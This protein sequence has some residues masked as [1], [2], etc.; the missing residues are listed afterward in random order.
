MKLKLWLLFNIKIGVLFV[1]MDLC[2]VEVGP[3]WYHQVTWEGFGN[4]VFKH[5]RFK[6]YV[7]A[8]TGNISLSTAFTFI[9]KLCEQCKQCKERHFVI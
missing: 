4:F 7:L 9:L 1:S 2:D 5:L 3:C 8:Q 6:F